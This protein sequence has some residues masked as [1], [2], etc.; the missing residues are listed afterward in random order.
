MKTL[1]LLR[2]AANNAEALKIKANEDRRVCE[3]PME[4]CRWVR[5][6]AKSRKNSPAG[7]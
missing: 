5:E 3:Q 1:N 2:K 6:H 4:I 7:S